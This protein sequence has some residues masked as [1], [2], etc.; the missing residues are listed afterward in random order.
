MKVN[1]NKLLLDLS[2][3]EIKDAHMGKLLAQIL[4]SSNSKENSIKMYYWA[5]KLYAEEELDLDPS[6]LKI[7]SDIVEQNETMTVL[8]KAQILE[9]LK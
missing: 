6:D 1:L 8:A 5:T 3:V 9:S 7:L 4:I 2:G